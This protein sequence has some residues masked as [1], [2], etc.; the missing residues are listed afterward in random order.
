MKSEPTTM[1]GNVALLVGHLEERISS[2]LLSFSACGF[3]VH[4]NQSETLAF[5]QC[6]TAF[7]PKDM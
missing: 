3:S 1:L 2:L 4:H 6:I 5:F 7:L